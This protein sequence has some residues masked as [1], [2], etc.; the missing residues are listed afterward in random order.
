[1]HLYNYFFTA[2][3]LLNTKPLIYKDILHQ[4]LCYGTVPIPNLQ[5]LQTFFKLTSVLD[6]FHGFVDT[7]ATFACVLYKI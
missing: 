1:M 2:N 4:F 7:P 3:I 5:F 6:A